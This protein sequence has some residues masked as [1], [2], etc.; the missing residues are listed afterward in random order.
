MAKPGRKSDGSWILDLLRGK[1]GIVN[2]YAV[3]S[4]VTSCEWVR[5]REWNREMVE[6]AIEALSDSTVPL[7]VELAVQW[8]R[9]QWYADTG[10]VDK[11]G[12]AIEWILRQNLPRHD[13]LTWEWEFV[14]FHAFS[15]R[16]ADSARERARIAE[17]LMPSR[18][19][20]GESRE[21]WKCRAA[22]AACEGRIEEARNAAAKAV[23]F[24]RSDKSY[25]AGL[26][27]ALEFD[28]AE[29]IEGC[30]AGRNAGRLSARVNPES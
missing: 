26:L 16:S 10:G 29:L 20:Y 14:W 22:I 1:P 3:R 11:A 4:L 23:S 28:L 24:A 6:L 7:E 17:G 15:G 30:N 27:K 13:R 25:A 5:P 2:V 9:Y 19:T 8:A 18:L 21:V 12:E